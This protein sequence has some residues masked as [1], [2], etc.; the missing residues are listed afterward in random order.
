MSLIESLLPS[1]TSQTR[2]H[3]LHFSQRSYYISS[4]RLA[5][6]TVSTQWLSISKFHALSQS[7]TKQHGQV[8]HNN[9]PCSWY[10]FLF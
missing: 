9:T 1:E 3:Y 10:Q 8:C 5:H 7:S 4:H 2:P 6:Y